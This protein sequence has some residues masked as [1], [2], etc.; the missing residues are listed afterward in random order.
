ME[1]NIKIMVLDRGRV[2]VGY[3]EP[4]PGLPFHWKI[5]SGRT[6]RRW[7]TT[8]G[9]EEIANNGPTTNTVLDDSCDSSCP[10]RAVIEILEVNQSR[11]SKHLK[12]T[13]SSALSIQDA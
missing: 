4:H 3:V 12:N 5:T 11:W 2:K 13:H 8:Q 9:L 6:I 7:G 1:K 10:Y